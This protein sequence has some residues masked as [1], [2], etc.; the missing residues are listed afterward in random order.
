MDKLKVI[1]AEDDP[2]TAKMIQLFCEK[3][4][5]EVIFFTDS[6]IELIEAC[7]KLKPDLVLLDIGLN[8]LDGISAIQ[9]LN[10]QDVFPQIIII[11]GTRDFNDAFN[12][13][14]VVNPL[15]FLSKPLQIDLFEI[16]VKKAII[17]IS[18]EKELNKVPIERVWI[19][20]KSF[21]SDIPVL[22][23]SI[24]YIEKEDRNSVIHLI[25]GEN[26]ITNS[27]ITEILVESKNLFNPYKGFLVNLNYISSYQKEKD[28]FSRRYH[29]LLLHSSAIIPLSRDKIKD[30]DNLLMAQ[31]K[32][33]Q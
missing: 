17:K 32:Q 11:S 4:N 20:V 22:E 18:Q 13:I 2:W 5:L 30:L 8:D 24:V 27:G 19:K 16:A 12:S 6:G 9:I 3:S 26:I 33:A 21:K 15:Y 10:E 1:I 28:L 7:K 29:L 25:N 14:N 31:P 23:E